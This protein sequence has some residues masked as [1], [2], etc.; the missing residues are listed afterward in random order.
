[1]TSRGRDIRGLIASLH[2]GCA[3]HHGAVRV[4][5]EPPRV[6]VCRRRPRG[7]RPQ[8]RSSS[9]VVRDEIGT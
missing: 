5:P 7:V 6:E 9:R 2:V 8:T 3:P 1:M 4:K